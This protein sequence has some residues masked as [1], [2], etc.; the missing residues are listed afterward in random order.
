MT[1][2]TSV[3]WRSAQPC[4]GRMTQPAISVTIQTAL[5]L[6]ASPRITV[7]VQTAFVVNEWQRTELA[8]WSLD[9]QAGG[10]P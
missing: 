7:I 2:T 10:I 4:R 6:S 8:N 3:S 1:E 9:R 5:H